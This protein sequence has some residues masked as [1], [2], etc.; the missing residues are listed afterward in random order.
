MAASSPIRKIVVAGALGAVSVVLVLFNIGF[1]PWFAGVSITFMHVPAIIGAI[2]EGP[3]VGGV[4][5]LIF[6]VTSILKAISSPLP[7]DKLFINPIIAVL[8]R[9]LVGI[10]AWAVYRVFRGKLEKAALAS[11]AVAGSLTNSVFVLG[12]LVI[13][14]PPKFGF[15]FAVAGGVLVGNG[16]IEAVVAAILTVAVVSAWKGIESRSGRARLADEAK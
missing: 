5:G 9:I 4:V 16:L 15:T 6:G 12:L 7:F 1:I 10:V 8:P 13:F 3:F 14:A 2:L 11:A